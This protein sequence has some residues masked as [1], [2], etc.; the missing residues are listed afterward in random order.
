MRPNDKPKPYGQTEVMD[1][2]KPESYGT[3]V[4]KGVDSPWRIIAL[5]FIGL[6][7]YTIL[8]G[9]DKVGVL[10]KLLHLCGM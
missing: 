10:A 1:T 8:Y 6:G 3:I 9:L 4:V 5:C 2:G 7:F